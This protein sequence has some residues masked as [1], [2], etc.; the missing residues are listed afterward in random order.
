MLITL[1]AAGTLVLAAITP[2]ADIQGRAHVSPF[3]GQ[4]VTTRGIVTT[5]TRNGFYL[6]DADGDDTTADGL[7]VYTA[8]TPAV[9]A[10]DDVEVTGTVVEFLPGGDPE[11]L[12][13]T[14]IHPSSLRILARGVSVPVPVVIGGSGRIPPGEVMDDDGLAAFDP[15]HDGLDFWESL[16][17]MRVRLVT[18]RVVGPANA[19]GEVWVV[20]E[21]G[22]SGMSAP[23]ALTATLRDANP[24]RI[25]IDDALLPA[26]MPAFNIGDGLADVVG[27]VDYRFGCYEVLPETAPVLIA[28]APAVQPVSLPGGHARLTIATFNV[29]NLSPTDTD[30]MPRIA[31]IVVHSLAAPGIL[32]LQEIQDSSGP[33]DDGVVDATATLDTLAAAIRRAGGPRYAAREIAP[34]DGADGGVP[35]GN[36]RVAVL[37]DTTRVSFVDRGAADASTGTMAVPAGD[38]VALTASPGRVDPGSPA[39]EAARKPMA[40]ELRAGGAPL[41]L[42]ACHFSSRSGTTP[43]FGSIQPP[44]DP[45]TGKRFAQAQIVRDFVQSILS[46]DPNARVIVAGDFN[47]DIFSGAL[48]PLSSSTALY[49]LHWRLPE[50]E[51]YSY[52][53]DGNAHA[54]DRILVSPALVTG[55]AMEVAHV[56]SGF[57]NAASDHDPV[58]ASVVMR[59]VPAANTRTGLVIESIRPNPAADT[60][61][62]IVSGAPVLSVAI[63]DARGRCVRRMGAA[64]ASAKE[65]HWDG[66]DDTGRRVAS[67]VYFVR[68]SSANGVA[69]RRMVRIHARE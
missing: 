64:G 9:L 63:Y 12:S 37:V 38:G 49:D 57:A 4:A 39:W 42:V 68:I 31:G 69:A 40:V 28:S 45:R 24:E 29:R 56:C 25:Q 48:A 36:I 10:A 16:E 35:G 1:V 11:N 13:V 65:F 46:I 32:V 59:R 15:M 62:I 52:V 7:F 30:R 18:P 51:R 50:A 47:D 26:P 14:E 43:D 20:V 22:F 21:D 23:G 3:A 27:V 58:A 5:V 33:V 55:A 41:F 54:Y 61:T 17:G 60:A 53:Y 67:G 66:N 2:I 34:A 44:F 6:Q 8:S 19:F